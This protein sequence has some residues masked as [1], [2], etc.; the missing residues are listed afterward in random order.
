[1]KSTITKTSLNAAVARLIELMQALNFGR[2]ERLQVRSGLP[3]FEPPPQIT[4]KLKMGGDNAPRP[5]VTYTDFRL[6]DGVIELL[7]IVQQLGNGEI[8]SIEVRCGLPVN[9]EID[10]PSGAPPS[11]AANE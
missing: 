3:A 11:G 1:L 4:Q 8:R 7:Q 6:K 2:I 9:V 10:W 5:E